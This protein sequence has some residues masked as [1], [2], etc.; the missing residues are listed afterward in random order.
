ML[1]ERVGPS[2]V[3]HR[4]QHRG[5]GAFARAMAAGRNRRWK[6]EP[7]RMSCW[8]SV[9]VGL[10][11]K[12]NPHSTGLRPRAVCDQRDSPLA[13]RRASS[14]RACSETRSVPWTREG[15]TVASGSTMLS[16]R[17]LHGI[18]MIICA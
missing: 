8:P 11:L 15:S 14:R 12:G 17:T 9:L 3:R 10:A 2:T 1:I 5:R 16:R 13:S 18:P 6:A 4:S 7:P